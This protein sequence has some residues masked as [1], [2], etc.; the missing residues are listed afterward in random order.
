MLIVACFAAFLLGPGM[1]C[2]AADTPEHRTTEPDKVRSVTGN[3]LS[4]A[5]A[6][7]SPLPIEVAKDERNEQRD[8]K[9]R[10]LEERIAHH[11]ADEHR[12]TTVLTVCA[13]LLSLSAYFLFHL[14]RA[15]RTQDTLHEELRR[16][17][18]KLQTT[19]D[20][21]PDL[22]F[23]LGLDGRYHYCHAP[24]AE[25]LAAPREDL[26]G[27]TVSEVLPPDAAR[28]CLSALREAQETGSSAGRQM[29]LDLP[30]GR[31]WFELSVARKT[32]PAGQ[33]PRFIVISRDITERKRLQARE[34]IRLRTFEMLATGDKLDEILGTVVRYVEQERPD[35]LCRVMLADADGKCLRS[36]IAPRLPA[37]HLAAIDVV[38]IGEGVCACGTAAWRR[39][40]V[41]IEDVGNHPFCACIKLL[42]AEAP[43]Y[44]C[45]SE[46][47]V[48]AAGTLLGTFAI[49]MRTP[50]GPAAADLELA[51]QSSHLA[52]TAIEH[53]RMRA[54][55]TAS[56]REFR[57]VAE[58]MPD[59][60]CRHDRQG[61]FLYLNPPLAATL[62]LGLR[63]LRGRTVLEAFP[64]GPFGDYQA[65]LAATIET[66]L[67]NEI[68][69]TLADIGEGPR[70]SHIRIVAER[71]AAGTIV[72][73][74]SIGRNITEFRKKE[75]QL[76]ASRDMLRELAARRD[77]ARE[78]ER[79]RIAREIHDELGQL[80]TAQRLEIATLKFQFG[81]HNAILAERCRRLIGVTDQ[82]IQV[83][84]NVAATLRPASLDMGIAAALEWLAGEFR[85]HNEVACHLHLDIPDLHLDEDQSIAVFRCVQESLT[86]VARY[87]AARQ[88]DI[89]LSADDND[90]YL[91][92]RDDGQGFDPE[93]V[94]G[95]SFGL[96]GMRERALLLGGD[97]RFVSAPGQGT[98]VEIRFPCNQ[99]ERP[100]S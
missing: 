61:R 92:I 76:E 95:T 22:L 73:T 74:L 57:S 5:A 41:V 24:R 87:A 69:V 88:V 6:T 82:T 11:A 96:V 8:L 12:M 16:S 2:H 28:T 94:R 14:R 15:Q 44:A 33:A 52:A 23:E 63:E 49:H 64:D 72:G 99:P 60:L 27:R 48:G 17:R 40:T 58:S 18:N 53:T 29:A 98:A 89:T 46:P 31:F 86:N 79:K 38:A 25:Q 70:Y 30:H 32:R 83:V 20:A 66:G 85:A 62:G 43:L 54:A 45:W 3:D 13:A 50:G 36:A 51:R 9:I 37:S 81:E 80:L 84:R 1:P 100:A 56:E 47:I 39:E 67:P 19:L 78:E 90:Y 42:A 71:D 75:K 21:I 55:L 97:A 65:R 4:K 68:E 26:V 10:E 91:S 7:A 93:G 34:E 77:S 59:H 35:L